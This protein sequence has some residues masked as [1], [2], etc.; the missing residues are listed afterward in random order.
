MRTLLGTFLVGVSL[1]A[2]PALAQQHPWVPSGT[3]VGS[4]PN[5][6]PAVQHPWVPSAYAGRLP[7]G[8]APARARADS[9]HH[10]G[11]KPVAGQ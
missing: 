10:V 2:S 4:L 6:D 7:S 1:V 9:R 8:G 3:P 5:G 11:H